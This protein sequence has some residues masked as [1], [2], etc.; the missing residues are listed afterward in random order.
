[1][2]SPLADLSTFELLPVQTIFGLTRANWNSFGLSPATSTS[3]P[4]SLAT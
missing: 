1:V 3:S 2:K 4:F